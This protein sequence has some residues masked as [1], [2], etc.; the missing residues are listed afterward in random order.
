MLPIAVG[1]SIYLDLN[2]RTHQ[3]ALALGGNVT[4]WTPAKRRRL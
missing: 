2:A 3:Q 4:Y 1:R